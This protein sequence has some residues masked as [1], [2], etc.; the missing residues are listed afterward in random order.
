MKDNFHN[1]T[2]SALKNSVLQEALQNVQ[3]RLGN[4]AKSK[5]SKLPETESLRQ[6]AHHI[7]KRAIA[8]LD[9]LLETLAE[10]VRANGGVVHFAEN[11]E[12]AVEYILRLAKTR[13]V[14]RVVKG[15]SMVTE[16][17]GLNR[18][19]VSRGIEVVETDLGEYILQL[20]DDHPSHIIAPAIHKTRFEVGR[21]FEKK[22]NIPYTDDPPSLTKAARKALRQKFLAADMGITGCNIACAETGHITVLSNEG[23][24]RMSSTIP[25]LHVAVMGMERVIES[26]EDHAVLFR[27][28]PTSAAAQ[29]MPAYLSYIGGPRNDE[30][31]DG[32]DAFHLVILDN[33]RSRILADEDFR[34]IL[35]CIRCAGCL[36][37]CPVYRKIGGHA[38]GIPYSGPIGA[39]IMPLLFGIDAYSDL[40][41]GETL[42]GACKKACPVDINIPRML[43]E[44]RHRLAAGDKRYNLAPKKNM[45]PL[46]FALWSLLMKNH[47]LYGAGLTFASRIQKLLPRKGES[48]RRLPHPFSGWTHSRNLQPVSQKPFRKRWQTLKKAQSH[49]KK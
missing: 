25:P 48:I 4:G 20:D 1:R 45:E 8:R 38:Y 46:A 15:K 23:N 5:Y 24:I 26:L 43:L 2:R 6:S 49:E 47:H 27:L 35:Y 29:N 16:E 30:E 7:R 19:L 17:I 18:A 3:Y 39:V 37:V 12:S 34:E 22:L 33:G 31:F 11:A 10:N 21:L 14:K 42:C 32:P 9:R 13:G 40:C 44:L 36:N 41:E 28:L